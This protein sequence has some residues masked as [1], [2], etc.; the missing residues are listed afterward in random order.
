VFKAIPASGAVIYNDGGFTIRFLLMAGFALLGLIVAVFMR[1]GARPT[2]LAET[3]DAVPVA[4]G[5][6]VV[7]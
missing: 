3:E 4:A 5:E 2:D 6:A 7:G 1:H